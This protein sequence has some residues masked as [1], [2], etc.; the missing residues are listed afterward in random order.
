[1]PKSPVA[2]LIVSPTEIQ[3]DETAI[4]SWSTQFAT[5]V[6]LNGQIVGKVGS[7]SIAGL[8][9]GQYT[10]TLFAHSKWG[11]ANVSQ[12]LVVINNPTPPA[13]PTAT[14]NVSPTVI[15]EGET[16]TLFWR[17]QGAH[18]VY[19][20]NEL[21]VE[22]SQKELSDFSVD[23]DTDY[24]YTLV[25]QGD[26][27]TISKEVVLRVNAITPQT[28]APTGTFDISPNTV[29]EGESATA[30]WTTQNAT[31]VKINDADMELNG[32]AII[33][34][35]PG[36]Q[37]YTFTAS[38]PGGVFTATDTLTVTAK[39][40]IPP[41]SR[42][43][44]KSNLEYMGA[45][46]LGSEYPGN[47]N[48]TY[49]ATA[50]SYNPVND[51]L[52]VV[53]HDWYQLVGEQKI[54]EIRKGTLNELAIATAVQRLVSTTARVPYLG[55]EGNVK[56]GGTLVV[57]GKLIISLYE[58]YDAN[59]NEY[60]SH[61]TV[62]PNTNLASGDVQ[63]TFRTDYGGGF[64]GGDLCHIPVEHQEKLGCKYAAGLNGVPIVSRTSLGPCLYGFDPNTYSYSQNYK[65]FPL[66]SYSLNNPMPGYGTE[67]GAL[68]NQGS[69][70]RGIII[71]NNS[72]SVLFIG[73]KGLGAYCFGGG[74]ADP[75]LVGTTSPDGV[76]WCY[77]PTSS[78]KGVHT[79]PYVDT[80]WAY[81]VNDMVKVKNGEKQP[82]EIGPYDTWT[83]EFP[84]WGDSF[85]IAG[86]CIDMAND[87]IFITASNSG[88]WGEPV[89]HVFKINRN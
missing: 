62:S 69:Y 68:W 86:A 66:L 3:S 23:A 85:N 61:Y 35:Q 83:F 13:A 82:W 57:D 43:L 46:R 21:V 27:G 75:G 18:S 55:I 70:S 4:I 12:V 76:Y 49:G 16:A 22:N 59:G 56:V 72:D 15:Y 84:G 30:T 29:M 20:N 28:P 54:P 47:E 19:I 79:Y 53:G 80:M 24:I 52:F 71:P 48:Y 42:L 1:M 33:N 41:A 6:T 17:T 87:R 60:Q 25:A 40:T 67:A 39:P 44:R 10:Y 36:T 89:I 64:L 65:S 14:F 74:T 38:G 26:G 63:G 50:L 2:S 9:A 45:F 37:V 88:P 51:S 8:E 32:G 11:V 78:S 7:M 34:Q 73:R 31:S 58:Y 77:D 5:T 81:D